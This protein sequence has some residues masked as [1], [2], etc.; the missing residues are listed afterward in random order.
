LLIRLALIVAQ[1]SWS[2]W[3]NIEQI[4][5][6]GIMKVGPLSM[7]LLPVVSSL[8]PGD[9]FQGIYT[10]MYLSHVSSYFLYRYLKE[11]NSD[12]TTFSNDGE[13]YIEIAD[14]KAMEELLDRET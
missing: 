9:A 6:V 5:I 14:T 7:Q 8:L 10:V 2:F 13:L 3:I 1:I 12:V 4:L 11:Q